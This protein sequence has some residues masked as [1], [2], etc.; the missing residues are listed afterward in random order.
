[1]SRFDIPVEFGFWVVELSIAVVVEKI[2]EVTVKGTVVVVVM[3]GE[4]A[5]VSVLISSAAV[6]E[7]AVVVSSISAVVIVGMRALHKSLSQ[8]E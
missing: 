8:H 2:A 7:S 6:V 4:P 5:L 1:M 3:V